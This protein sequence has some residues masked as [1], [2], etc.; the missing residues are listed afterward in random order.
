M[1]TGMLI[2]Y[3]ALLVLA[4]LP[5]FL[6]AWDSI[7]DQLNPSHS[8]DEDGEKVAPQRESLSTSDAKMFPVF[9]SIALFSL[10][11][12]FKF[13]EEQYIN[14]LLGAY[15]G[16]IGVASLATQLA[17]RT[18]WIAV[19][20]KLQEFSICLKEGKKEIS[21]L[22]FTYLAFFGLIVSVVVNIFY[23]ITKNWIL[24][25]LLAFAFATSGIRMIQLDTF[26]TGMIL[27]GG[28]FFYDIFWVFGTEVMV[29]VA[30]NFDAPVKMLWPKDLM[31][32]KKGFTMLGLGDIVI[33]GIY[34]S[35]CLRYD[36]QRYIRNL[37]KKQKPSMDGFLKYPKTYFRVNFAAYILA[38]V[39]TVVVMHTFQ[40]AQPA[41]LYLSPACTLA[42]FLTSVALKDVSSF[43]DFTTEKQEEM[44]EDLLL[45]KSPKGKGGKGKKDKDID[46]AEDKVAGEEKENKKRKSEGEVKVESKKRKEK[47][48]SDATSAESKS[49]S[50]K[51]DSEP[52]VKPKPEPQEKKSQPSEPEQKPST[53]PAPTSTSSKKK[54]KNKGT[55]TPESSSLSNSQSKP[56]TQTKPQS[57]ST[58]GLDNSSSSQASKAE[59]LVSEAVSN[60]DDDM[61]LVV[62]KKKNR[63]LKKSESFGMTGEGAAAGTTS[64]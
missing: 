13:F 1:D 40:A 49:D 15:F 54:K 47:K 12:I 32:T 9:G 64:N 57:S 37:P 30:K 10:Y 52:E 4:L 59:N 46:A 6:G 33:P 2:A 41:L 43:W 45:P 23:V 38:L 31:A 11:L 20:L 48:N 3:V 53:P 5:I 58:N 56:Q 22:N 50:K 51:S 63:R 55:S 7:H 21:S 18:H 27:L 26:R 8:V 42:S 39:T 14:Y 35:L 36:L 29:T 61:V 60:D 62:N 44:L 17:D 34:V 24:S 25:N 16:L 19:M 28:L